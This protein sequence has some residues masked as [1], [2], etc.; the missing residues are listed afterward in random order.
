MSVK[1]ECTGSEHKTDWYPTIEGCLESCV[2]KSN[3]FIYSRRD[4]KYCHENK[5]QCYCELST[6]D[7][8]KCNEK[9]NTNW[10]L[11]LIV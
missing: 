6:T 10:D 3:M 5:C 7:D 9:S 4:G 1:S 11:Y 2:G 8:G